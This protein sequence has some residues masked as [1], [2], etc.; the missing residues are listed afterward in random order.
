MVVK[1]KRKMERFELKVFSKIQVESGWHNTDTIELNTENICSNGA[2]FKTSKPLPV[3]TSV[4]LAMKLKVNS[5]LKSTINL[6]AIEV[7][8]KVIR[9]E[10]DGMAIRFDNGYKMMPLGNKP[11]K[12]KS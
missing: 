11:K 1:E 12:K 10:K 9:S 2:Y 3:G 6:M 7:S 8:G 4:S 5:K